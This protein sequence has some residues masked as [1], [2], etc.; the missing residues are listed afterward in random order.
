MREIQTEVVDNIILEQIES[1]VSGT[2]PTIYT[3]SGKLIRYF[4]LQVPDIGPNSNNINRYIRFSVNGGVTYSTLKRGEAI[5]IEGELLSND[6]YVK[7]DG[8]VGSV[9]F[10]LIL[11]LDEQELG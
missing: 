9:K 6:L 5:S 4:I 3:S 1:S 2:S 7:A 8:G 11:G 10:E